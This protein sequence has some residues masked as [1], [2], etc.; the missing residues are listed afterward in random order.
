[1]KPKKRRSEFTNK[2]EIYEE[3]F[4]SRIFDNLLNPTPMAQKF[5]FDNDVN[6]EKMIDPEEKIIE[7]LGHQ[8]KLMTQTLKQKLVCPMCE[9]KSRLKFA[10]CKSVWYCSRECQTAHWPKH[11]KICNEMKHVA[12]KFTTMEENCAEIFSTKA[13]EILYCLITMQ[14]VDAEVVY[15][16]G[17]VSWLPM[18]SSIFPGLAVVI[19]DGQ[20][21][22]P[23]I[24]LPNNRFFRPG[25]SREYQP[26]PEWDAADY[27]QLSAIK[28]SYIMTRAHL[29]T[30]L[31]YDKSI[32]DPVDLRRIKLFEIWSMMEQHY[33]DVTDKKSL[34]EMFR[35]DNIKKLQEATGM[36][37]KEHI[38]TLL[39]E[40]GSEF[41]TEWIFT[42]GWI[43]AWIELELKA[44]TRDKIK[45]NPL[46]FY[47]WEAQFEKEKINGQYPPKF[48]FPDAPFR[49]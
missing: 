42:E 4:E 40:T 43:N 29:P 44:D 27:V 18:E 13:A 22:D 17:R 39:E 41:I 3:L 5:R 14:N 6:D 24:L 31:V 30:L 1:M 10:R 9:T 28:T 20:I 26:L 19:A 45:F 48:C 38:D 23:T 37:F 7:W 25:V 47:D 2:G 16:L 35:K 46:S 34:V 36:H 21:F 12:A 15:C 49:Q 8:R 33:M 11:K 32:I